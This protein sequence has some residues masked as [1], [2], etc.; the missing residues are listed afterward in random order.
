MKTKPVLLYIILFYWWVAGN[1]G[2][3]LAVK[4]PKSEDDDYI[5]FIKTNVVI[6]WVYNII[7]FKQFELKRISGKRTS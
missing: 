6:K 2:G 7:D 3:W 4:R 5:I 1:P